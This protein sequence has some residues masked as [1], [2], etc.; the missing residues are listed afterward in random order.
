M[1]KTL[2]KISKKEK[3]ELHK[4]PKKGNFW[5]LRFLKRKFYFRQKLNYTRFH[6]RKFQITVFPKKEFYSLE[7]Y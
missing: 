7:N 6:K 3:I 5:L 4:I 1:H 2:H